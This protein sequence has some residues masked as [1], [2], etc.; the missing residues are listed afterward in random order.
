MP[1]PEAVVKQAIKD[2]LIERGCIA[3]GSKEGKWPPIVKGWFFMPVPSG[4]GV[5]G[6]PDF[7]GQYRQRF[8]AVEAKAE[9]KLADTSA[10]QDRRLYEMWRST[11]YAIVADTPEAVSSLLDRIDEAADACRS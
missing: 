9:G 8:F 7:L 11:P 10:N 2:V 6:I 1:T 4:L 3:A 5:H